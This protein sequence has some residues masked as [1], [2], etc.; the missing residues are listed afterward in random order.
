MIQSEVVSI[1]PEIAAEILNG[2]TSNRP[3]RNQR[4]NQ[5]AQTM[6]DGQFVLNGEP[7]IISKT[8]RL[9]DGQHRLHA[10][11]QSGVTI[12]AVI[13]RGLEDEARV[14]NTLGQAIRRSPGDV[15]AMHGYRDTVT[16]SS[17]LRCIHVYQ[18]KEI[19]MKG[20][21]LYDSK[22]VANDLYI[23]IAEDYPLAIEAHRLARSICDK[24]KAAI[25][26]HRS[27][28]GFLMV[29]HLQEKTAEGEQFFNELKTQ[30]MWN[31]SSPSYMLYK[32]IEQMTT[33]LS[34]PY[35]GAV[36]ALAI[37][38]YHAAITG[39]TIK[40]LAIAEDE[41]FPYWLMIKKGHQ[42]ET[43]AEDAA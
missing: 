6:R 30:T 43:G 13:T 8:G 37:K 38:A 3:I 2:N 5:L 40:R 31:E 39:R 32:K 11:I 14:F 41:E 28:F 42:A 36:M 24:Q 1:T 19:N 20:P 21:S 12:Q 26:G 29:H 33:R 9:L 10:V 35:Q 25:F 18:L 15:L 34:K 17:L 22:S 16:L 7:V 23:Q 27:T 4:V